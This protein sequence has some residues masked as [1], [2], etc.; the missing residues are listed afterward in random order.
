MCDV[1]TETEY[2]SLCLGTCAGAKSLEK[3]P[4]PTCQDD[5]TEEELAPYEICGFDMATYPN[6]CEL[7]CLIG[8]PETCTAIGNCDQIEHPGACQPD[9][10][11]DEGCSTDYNPLCGSNGVTYCNK[12]ALQVCGAGDGAEIACVG[13][14]HDPVACPDCAEECEPVC[15]LH[16]GD[17]KNFGSACLMECQ[18]GEFLWEGE[19]CL[20]CDEFEQWVCAADGEGS[21]TTYINDCF[22]NCQAPELVSLYEVP[23]L[24][25]G[26]VWLDLCEDCKCDISEPEPVCGD[27]YFTYANACALACASGSNPDNP[28]VGDVP[29]CDGACFTEECPCPPETAGLPVPGQIGGD[30]IRGVC[31]ADGNTY[32]NE[33]HA[34]QYG[35]F[36]VS[37][38]WCGNC[39]GLCA[40]DDY[41]P[42]CCSGVTYP[43]SCIADKCNDELDPAAVCFK[44]KCCLEDAGCDDENADT[45]DTCNNGVCENI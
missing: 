3:G 25:N 18:A 29:I 8:D 22:Q 37:Q 27:D 28:P 4:C 44:G 40:Q 41:L 32:G 19:C 36:I 1:N 13:Q 31:G 17:K 15:G 2:A 33:C 7:K 12:C 20:H 38:S 34:A 45:V 23:L 5:C 14:C 11:E 30:G 42:V 16:D 35:T 43:N 39:A 10:C 9:C 24:P 21:Y 26:D 6:F